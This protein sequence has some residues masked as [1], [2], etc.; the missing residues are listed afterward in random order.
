[1]GCAG[2]P[3]AAIPESEANR[4]RLPGEARFFYWCFAALAAVLLLAPLRAGD[5]AGYDDA[6]YAHIAKDI[7]VTGDWLNLRSNGARIFEHPP[8]FVWIEAA[9]FRLFG[10]SDFVARLPSALCGWGAILLVYSLARRLLRDSF[11]AVA[12]MFVMASTLYFLKYAARA[13]TDV[14]FT[15][16]CLC[17]LYSWLRAEEEPRWYAWAGVFAGLA[18]ITRGL[19]GVA[20][21]VAFVLDLAVN[22]RRAPLRSLALACSLSFLPLIAWYGYIIH[23]NHW[24]FLKDHATW[25]NTE[26]FGALSPPWRRYTGVFEYAWMLLKSYWPWLPFTV[27]GLIAA[28]RSEDRRL[29]FLAIWVAVVFLL[30]AAAKSRVLRYLLPAYPAF[31]IF[32]AMS[33]AQLAPAA[34][35]WRGLRIATAAG[36]AVVAMIAIFPRNPAQAAEIRPIAAAETA[37]TAPGERVAFYDRGDPRFDETNQLQWYGDR[38]LDILTTPQQLADKLSRLTPQVFVVDRETYEHYF[39]ARPHRMLAGSGHLICFRLE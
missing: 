18:Q 35:F 28:I 6:H 31:S 14:P 9:F 16:L 22:R 17:A 19:M 3:M 26:A 12:A 7:L 37:A 33:L 34:Y 1:V 39:A 13:M 15:L 24:S 10:K 21:P 2:L 8:L 38:Y 30:C 20:L 23:A 29:R 32:A 11:V 4:A 27:F 36:A 5:L 25:L